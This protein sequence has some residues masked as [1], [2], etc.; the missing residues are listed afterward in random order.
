MAASIKK[1]FC[2]LRFIVNNSHCFSFTGYIASIFVDKGF[3]DIRYTNMRDRSASELKLYYAVQ[4]GH[5]S[6]ARELVEHGIDVNASYYPRSDSLLHDAVI[7]GSLPMVQLLL[8]HG[9]TIF[10]GEDNNTPLHLAARTEKEEIGI[11][12][13][14]I[15]NG[16][17]CNDKS[18]MGNTPFHLALSRRSLKVIQ[19]LLIYGADIAAKNNNGMTAIHMAAR[20]RHHVDVLEYMLELGL[21]IQKRS[22]NHWSALHYAAQFRNFKG[23]ELLLK[24]GALATAEAHL[25]DDVPLILAIKKKPLEPPCEYEQMR[26]VQVL[27]EHGADMI[28]KS[29]GKCRSVLKIATEEKVSEGVTN[30]LIQ[31]MAK[32]HHLNV[33]LNEEDRQIIENEDRHKRYYQMCLQELGKMKQMMFY[34]RVSVFH[35]LTESEKVISGLARNEEIIEAFEGGDYGDEFPIYFPSVKTRFHAKVEEN[36]FRHTAAEILGNL[37]EF[38]DPFHPIVQ[39]ILSYLNNKDLIPLRTGCHDESSL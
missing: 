14:L 35:I 10:A 7:N 9:A 11:F 4:Y 39:K 34:H 31:H 16:A 20:N 2:T 33:E 12:R 6:T 22:D 15:E 8:D 36:R 30:V 27:L 21:D 18:Y 38:N 26:T 5:L 32:M 23:C 37:F 19:M 13:V 17:S 29:R 3:D 25:T 24:H 1:T 28:D